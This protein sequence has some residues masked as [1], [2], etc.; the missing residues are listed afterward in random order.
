MDW[1]SQA[2]VLGLQDYSEELMIMSVLTAAQGLRKGI[3]RS[4]KKNKPALA[5]GNII[6]A[7]WRARLEAHLGTFTI[8]SYE[9]I[10]QFVYHERQKL[11]ALLSICELF[12]VCLPEKEP[13][14][15][16][17]IHLEDF[18][19]ALRF[20]NQLW[21]NFF[22][23]LELELLSKI[24]FGLALDKCAATGATTNLTYISP[25]TGKAVSAVSGEVYKNKLFLLPKLFLNPSETYENKELA[26]ALRVTRY[27]FMKNVFANK[28]NQFPSVRTTLEEIF[29][30]SVVQ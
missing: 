10:A 7:Q 26:L 3:I 13:Q 30:G 27:F 9:S 8:Q 28:Q 2:I 29:N 14:E 17:Y 12:K 20:N 6:K 21:A 11:L 18:L 1:E 4:T 19:Y 16:L 15:L 24:G 25:W 22:A 5:A 23:M